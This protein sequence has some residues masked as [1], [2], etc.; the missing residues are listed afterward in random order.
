MRSLADVVGQVISDILS[1]FPF[2][3]NR[4]GSASANMPLF[5]YNTLTG[6][7]Q[8]FT[9]LQRGEVKMYNCG[10][11]VYGPQHIGNLSMFVFV[12]LLRRTLEFNGYKVKQAINFTDVG[13]LTGDNQGDADEGEDRMT[14]GLKREGMELTLENMRALG[15][16]YADLFLEDLKL[17]NINTASTSFPR[18][19]DYI[20]QQIEMV[21][22][23]EKKG[24]AYRGKQGMYFDS[25]KFPAYGT[26]GNIDLSGIREGARVS[27]TSDKKNPTDFL[28]WKLSSQDTLGW[29]SPW[30]KGYPGWHIE[31]SVMSRE[32]L[33]DQID[34]HTGG[35]EHIPIHHNNEIAQSESATGKKPFSRFWLHRA[36]VQ[37]EGAKIAKS[38]GNTIY[39]SNVVERG[40]SPLVFRYLL[41]GAHYRTPASFSWDGMTAAQT[42]LNRLYNLYGSFRDNKDT[43]KNADPYIDMFR[44]RINDDVDTPGALAVVWE[45]VKDPNV[46]AV[47]KYNALK[48][49]D[50]VLGLKLESGSAAN[51]V[52]ID[53]LPPEVRALVDERETARGAKDW[54]RADELRSM[55]AAHGFNLED[56]T[57]G[58]RISQK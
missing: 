54:K 20:P 4:S 8:E 58:P 19:S 18:A 47:K 35:I 25:S 2:R 55:V 37:I 14:K 17:L 5:F 32:L 57:K 33:G 9:M 53:E 22:T 15:K 46:S 21:K 43:G 1:A 28:L 44:K 10:P 7:K 27:S 23:L 24:F 12:D 29:D 11:T 42:S 13:H 6:K 3:M 56:S 34:I 40:F 51:N 31:C 16:K 26:L 36:H 50:A 39:V 49:F 52:S 48:D 38:E 45:L 30:G 41:L